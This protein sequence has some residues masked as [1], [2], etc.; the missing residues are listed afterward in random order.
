M[1]CLW[2]LEMQKKRVQIDF[3]CKPHRP[4]LSFFPVISPSDVTGASD[5]NLSSC[6]SRPILYP[7]FERIHPLSHLH[8]NNITDDR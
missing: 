4:E 8:T 7:A 6:Y 1:Q 3:A 2:N 5:M